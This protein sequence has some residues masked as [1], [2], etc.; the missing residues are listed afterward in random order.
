MK[1][2]NQLGKGKLL[3]RLTVRKRAVEQLPNQTIR[4]PP[5]IHLLSECTN[6]QA[7]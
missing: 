6:P 5:Q 2:A 7:S 1:E 3:A 4:M